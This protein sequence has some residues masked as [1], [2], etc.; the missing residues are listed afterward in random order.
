MQCRRDGHHGFASSFI[1]KYWLSKRNE[2]IQMVRGQQS[3]RLPGLSELRVLFSRQRKVESLPWSIVSSNTR[4]LGLS[5]RD[6][7]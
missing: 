1:P 5:Q 6:M 2:T 4:W 3:V 7:S